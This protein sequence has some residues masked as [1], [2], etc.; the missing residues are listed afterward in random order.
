MNFVNDILIPE[1]LQQSAILN[2][3][4]FE[5]TV[6][7]I[8]SSCAQQLWAAFEEETTMRVRSP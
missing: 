3:K 4:R 8:R 5:S 6:N 7:A 1:D 2:V